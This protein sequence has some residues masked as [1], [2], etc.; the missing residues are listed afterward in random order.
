MG[1][2]TKC[3]VRVTDQPAGTVREANDATVLLETDEVIVRG[4]AGGRVPRASIERVTSRAG[5]VTITS[6]VAVVSLSLGKEAAEK[7]QKK[8]AE[9]PKQLIDKLDVKPEF[10][11]W[12]YGVTD[13]DLVA[14]IEARAAKVVTGTAA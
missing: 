10:T 2:E 7:W 3:R 4:H 14:Q 6:P 5:V 8:L 9:A 1:Y 13:T 11:V 12:L